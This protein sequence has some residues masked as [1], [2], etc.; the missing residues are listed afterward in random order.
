MKFVHT[1]IIARDWKSLAQFYRD[2]FDCQFAPPE[3]DLKGEWA[4]QLSGI[5]NVRICGAHLTLPGYTEGPTLE[6]FQYKPEVAGE[7]TPAV[8]RPGY[9][10]L[11]FEVDCVE[12]IVQ[13]LLAHGGQMVGKIINNPVQ[14][15]GVLTAA[16]ARDPEGNI[17]EI[18][19]W[20]R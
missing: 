4:D 10:H 18:L 8:N 12:D 7:T 3:R 15:V 19:H 13:K 16:Y 17:V 20:D 1:N 2:V 5:E 6:I 11:A 9:S 14:G